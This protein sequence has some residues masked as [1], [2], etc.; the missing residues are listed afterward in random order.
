M[1]S[2]LPQSERW[3]AFRFSVIGPLYAARPDH[4]EL[5][6]A[7][8]ELSRQQFNH[9]ITGERVRF[10]YST[11]ERWYYRAVDN[12]DPMRELRRKVRK[13]AGEFKAVGLAL[14]AAIRSQYEEHPTWSYQLHYE[15]LDAVVDKH[16]ELGPLPS[17]TTVRRYMRSQGLVRQKRR[18]DHR[19]QHSPREVRSY[20]MADAHALWHLDFHTGKRRVLLPNGEYVRPHLL[21]ILDDHSRVVCH[22]QWYLGE[23]AE[24]LVHGLCQAFL[25]RGLPRGILMDNG[26][27]MVSSEVKQGLLR[28]GIVGKYT[29]PESPHQN[30]KQETFFAPLEG[31]CVAML[32]GVRDLE[33]DLLNRATIAWVEQDYHRRE[34]Q[35]I[36]AAPLERLRE[37]HSEARVS[38]SLETLRAAFREELERRQR[39]GDGTISV[40]GIRFEVPSLYRHLEKVHVRVAR[41][42]LTRV[43]MVDPRHG[44]VLAKLHPL[45][46]QRNADGHRKSVDPTQLIDEPPVESDIAPHMQRLLERANSTGLPAAFI[47]FNED[48]SAPE[49]SHD[50]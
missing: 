24:H 15:N 9:P 14:R 17:Y 32:E 7:L 21:A 19:V 27:A 20:E 34:H 2:T 35:G 1:K 38:P 43:T 30:G 49:T 36:G 5:R 12:G 22:A 50:D 28:L 8:E 3:A 46:R 25:K 29:L 6:P 26:A 47:P 23:T 4:G 41:W 31:K 13:D 40:H 33:L 48:S 42:D 45:D 39:R 44:H 16:P 11:L 37:A 18:T 10:A